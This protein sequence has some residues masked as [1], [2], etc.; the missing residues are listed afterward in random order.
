M[1]LK[2]QA[3][4]RARVAFGQGDF[5]DAVA[6][7]RFWV[8]R[9]PHAPPSRVG[10]AFQDL[11]DNAIRADPALAAAAIDWAVTA[12]LLA[13]SDARLLRA[14]ARIR[15]G[16]V[17]T[18][19]TLVAP[20]LDTDDPLAKH[21]VLDL[22]ADYLHAAGRT[23]LASQY[24]QRA[25]AVECESCPPEHAV[26]E[27]GLHQLASPRIDRLAR[28]IRDGG[29]FALP[30]PRWPAFTARTA[31]G[32]EDLRALD[33]ACADVQM[34]LHHLER[35]ALV[36]AT[37]PADPSSLRHLAARRGWHPD[38]PW[39]GIRWAVSEALDGHGSA[40]PPSPYEPCWCGRPLLYDDCCRNRALGQTRPP[41]SQPVPVLPG[42]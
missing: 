28:Q 20:L 32:S 37:V 4:A 33:Q 13:D 41:F 2:K 19:L 36:L 31:D 22:L 23:D 24:R 6:E 18:A 42:G 9:D 17:D 38:D 3:Q 40:W 29:L 27:A 5:P 11:I 25:G 35:D 12:R 8:D 1:S 16:D 30:V 15:A 14:A 26:L 34:A 39:T 21:T 7:L 10:G